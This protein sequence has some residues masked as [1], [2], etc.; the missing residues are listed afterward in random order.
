MMHILAKKNLKQIARH[1]KRPLT[2]ILPLFL[3]VILFFA[4]AQKSFGAD[5]SV[6]WKKIETEHFEIVYD[7]RHHQL[8]K[9]FARHA[10]TAWTTLV[11]IFRTW[12]DKTVVLIDDSGDEANGMATGLPYPQIH[13]YPASPSPGETIGDT[14]PW[15]LELMT[16]EYAHVLN[17]QPAHGIFH[18]LRNIFGTIVRP[19]LLLPRW[20]LEGLA[21]EIETRFS[22]SGGRLRSPDFTAIP[23]AMVQD[24][25][26]RQED[27]ARVGE[28]SIPDWPGGARPYLLGGFIW[29]KLIKE[30]PSI[31]GDLNDHYA[32]RMPFFIDTPLEERTGKNWQSYLESTYTE[33]EQRA[34]GQIELLCENGCLEGAKL[35][36]AGFFSRAPVITHALPFE[37]QALAFLT[38]EHN[39]DSVVMIVERA[40]DSLD[41][42]FDFANAKRAAEP[43][44]AHRI[45][46]LPGGQELIHDGIDSFGRYEE[47]SD[48]WLYR[49]SDKKKIRLSKGLRAREPDVSLDGKKVA[50]VQ[51]RPGQTHIAI[52][53]LAPNASGKMELGP[54]A[55]LYAPEKDHRVSWP[56]FT[57]PRTLVFVER[58]PDAKE[59]LKVLDLRTGTS[60]IAPSAA[61]PRLVNSGGSV[62]FPRLVLDARTG[63]RNLLFTSN[64][65][66]VSNIYIADLLRDVSQETSRSFALE[67]IRPLTNSVTRAWSADY[68]LSNE[69]LI[70]S[71]LDGNGSRLRRLTASDRGQNQT[72]RENR[73]I[74]IPLL[75]ERTEAPHIVP[76]AAIPESA[77]AGEDFS[78]WPYLLPRYWMPYAAFVP[79]GA[80]LSAS[81]SSGDP[82]GR[83]LLAT[84]I[85]TDTRIGKPNFFAAY[86]NATTRVRT[87]LM[88]DDF[89]Q[90]LSSSGFDRRSS[91]GDLSGTFFIPALSNSWR[92][93]LGLS[94]QRTEIPLTAGG[95]DVRIRGGPRV[96]VLWQ[97]LEQKGF[98]ISPE[99][100]G[101]WRLTHAR[102]LP[103]LGNLVYD[104]TDVSISSYLSRVSTPDVFGAK[105]FGWLPERHVFNASLTA[106]WL[107]GLDRLLLGPSSVSLPV[108]TVALGASSTSFV[109]RGYPS[110][111]FLARKFVRGSLEHRFPL[112]SSYHGFGTN[113]AF[114]KR[115]HGAVFAD[116]VTIEGAFFDFEIDNYRSSGIG[117]MF[118]TI[119]AEARI[120][121]TLFY[122]LPV[123][124]ILGYHWGFDK[125]AN[126]NGAYPIISIAL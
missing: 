86:S 100:G 97:D 59:V 111:T 32:R 126:P 82:M 16:H 40:A 87:T 26:L 102:F 104:K 106:S 10:E 75:I 53:D 123:Q 95:S 54:P 117:N 67:N 108:E 63:R 83:H 39:H 30:S 52:A 113:P 41:G 11:P 28:T 37:K 43:T 70:Y 114:I 115:W 35:G 3:F 61:A 125:R 46:W 71:R 122:H 88:V 50:F 47:R 21:V 55:V 96:G 78:V 27:I 121:T 19:N 29:Q 38:R 119:G 116:L 120:D 85:S 12:P 13:L 72:V 2:A 66:G 90:R 48:L 62:T 110:G 23:R 84:S 73:L 64:R 94:H 42:G 118:G 81:T 101:H 89:W 7:S 51:L 79:G 68:D 57:G 109:M 91:T 58:S 105:L 93:E 69:T 34:V 4:A 65:T 14:G 5:P 8:A 74:K 6:E 45:A 112:S 124:F 20:Y 60:V 49:R 15:G 103:E 107:P 18:T 92:G 98:E 77:L 76:D 1:G 56:T 9:D 80:F 24:N 22:P 36:E 17:F 44:S 25:I 31:V 99:K 33:I